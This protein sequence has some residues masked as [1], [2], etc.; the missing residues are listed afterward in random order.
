MKQLLK[1][2]V[3][4]AIG[5]IST[6]F[7]SFFL[8]P[9]YTAYLSTEEY[10]VVDLLNTYVSLLLPLVFLQ[11]DQSIFRYLIDVRKDEDGKKKLITTTMI[12]VFI[13][14]LIFLVIFVIIAQFIKNDYKYFLATNVI[15]A[16][17]SNLVLQIS[18]GLGD[19]ATYSQG[20]LVSGAGSIILNVAFI[21][22]LDMGAYGMLLAT[23]IANVLCTLFVIIKLKLYKY[24][25]KD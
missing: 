21:V 6:K 11:I 18:R 23:L 4:V 14:S 20:S 25:K 3:I 8:L 7:I 10:G 22:G 12:T 9:L 15:A 16:M 17:I 2:T 13:Q 24:I 19:N 1:N 5:Q